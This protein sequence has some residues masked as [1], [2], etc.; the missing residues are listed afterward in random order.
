MSRTSAPKRT[1]H[2]GDAGRPAEPVLAMIGPQ[3]RHRRFLADPLGESPDVSVEDQVAN[4]H[5]A[6][7]AEP[8]EPSNQVVPHAPGT[9]LPRKRAIHHERWVAPTGFAVAA[10][11]THGWVATHRRW[12]PSSCRNMCSCNQIRQGAGFW[13]GL[14]RTIDDRFDWFSSCDPPA[15]RA[16]RGGQAG[17]ARAR[18]GRRNNGDAVTSKACPGFASEV[19]KPQSQFTRSDL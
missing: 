18:D 15:Y 10:I 5:D 13:N 12:P 17:I 4:D 16:W 9:P 6:R 14:D 8:L 11:C 3:E 7:V 1:Q 19:R 2:R